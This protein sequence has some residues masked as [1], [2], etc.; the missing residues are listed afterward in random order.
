MNGEKDNDPDGSY[1][2]T[3]TPLRDDDVNV[4]TSV[5]GTVVRYLASLFTTT[6]N[7]P[8]TARVLPNA[9]QNY[10]SPSSLGS[11]L[12][13]RYYAVYVGTEV[14]VFREWYFIFFLSFYML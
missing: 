10:N 13:V 9:Q 6:P 5:L 8:T 11:H 12:T 4:F 7:R 3:S 2:N 14:G 1:G